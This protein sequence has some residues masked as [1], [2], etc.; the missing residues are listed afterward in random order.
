M[1]GVKGRGGATRGAG[2]RLFG[3]PPRISAH[4]SNSPSFLLR[5]QIPRVRLRPPL[6]S[7]L[8]VPG[9]WGRLGFLPPH[10]PL[11]PPAHSSAVGTLWALGKYL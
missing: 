1:A 9:G 8:G 3:K 2:G 4:P 6:P 7:G 10:P 5:G 11:P